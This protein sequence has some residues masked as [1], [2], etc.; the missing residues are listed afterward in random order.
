MENIHRKHRGRQVTARRAV[1]IQVPVSEPQYRHDG[2]PL[3][4]ALNNPYQQRKCWT[5]VTTTCINTHASGDER[6]TPNRA[7]ERM[8]AY[9]LKGRPWG[10]RACERKAQ[11]EDYAVE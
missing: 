5:L 9:S 10:A 1:V 3:A 11:Q 6:P 4:C 8:P 7:A 2:Q